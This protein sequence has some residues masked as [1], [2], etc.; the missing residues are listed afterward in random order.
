[1]SLR[2]FSI[3]LCIVLMLVACQSKS[4]PPEDE[5]VALPTSVPPRQDTLLERTGVVKPVPG[6]PDYDTTQWLEVTLLDPSIR[7]DIKYATTDNFVEEKMYECGRCFLRPKVARRLVKIHQVFQKKGYGLLLYD[8]YRPL[9]IQQ[10][11]WNK[12]PDPRYVTN[13]KKGSMHNRG[14]AVD[15]TLVDAQNNVLEMGT[16]YDYFGEEA[17]HT[18]RGHSDQIQANRDLLK[19]TME[20]Y[21]FGGI[22]T[23]WWHY[24]FREKS[25]ALSDWVW[26]CP[27]NH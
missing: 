9:P 2:L 22:R 14:A 5:G 23:E 18:Y 15:L 6:P 24:S 26:N 4:E 19:N 1:M 16:G 7:I 25:Y 21:G 17:Y 11:L 20:S 27:S 8:C 10:K 3:S 12:V 13:P